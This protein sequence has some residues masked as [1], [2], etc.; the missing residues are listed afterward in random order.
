MAFHLYHLLLNYSDMK[1]L[2]GLTGLFIGC[3]LMT[4][5]GQSGKERL[6]K[7]KENAAEERT[8]S[9]GGQRTYNDLLDERQGLQPEAG[10]D[11]EG[12]EE[13]T[14]AREEGE[15]NPGGLAPTLEEGEEDETQSGNTNTTV[16]I[17]R[18]SS[19][20]G[21]P[22]VLSDD[23]GRGRDGTGNVQRAQPNMVGSPVTSDMNLSERNSGAQDEGRVQEIREQEE[24]PQTDRNATQPQDAQQAAEKQEP[25]VQ[26][27]QDDKKTRREERRERRK[28]RQ[29]DNDNS[30]TR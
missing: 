10:K 11:E 26:A 17:D 3:I 21:S 30:G 5:N 15:G 1:K 6:E 14:L 13:T 2:M 27:D 23:D 7:A 9:V 22:A 29:N 19:G 24:V 18:T 4:A 12:E 8:R 25:Q 16:V 28:A 20:A